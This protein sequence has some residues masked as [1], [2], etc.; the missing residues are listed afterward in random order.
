MSPRYGW[1]GAT[2]REAV[3]V[4]VTAC[5]VAWLRDWCETHESVAPLVEDSATAPR[6]PGDVHV[7]HFGVP[8]DDPLLALAMAKSDRARLGGGGAG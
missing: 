8:S 2:R 6:S 4:M 7:L 5:V 3:R 1:I